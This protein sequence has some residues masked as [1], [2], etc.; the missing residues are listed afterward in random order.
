MSHV[1][2][3]CTSQPLQARAVRGATR[4][5][6]GFERVSNGVGWVSDTRLIQAQLLLQRLPLSTDRSAHTLRRTSAVTL[7][8][9]GGG[10][11]MDTT[12]AQAQEAS[13][14]VRVHVLGDTLRIQQLHIRSAP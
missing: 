3:G 10:G 12:C 14:I 4:K 1:T 2:C 7:V 9:A 11:A 13:Q 5:G 6:L 8:A